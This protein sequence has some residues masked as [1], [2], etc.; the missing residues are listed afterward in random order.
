MIKD[1]LNQPEEV[2]GIGLIYPVSILEWETFSPLAHRFL[3]VG[4]DHLK[5]RLKV[6]EEVKL[7]DFIIAVCLNSED[8][9]ER[10]KNL[11]SL[12]QLIELVV[13]KETRFMFDKG[14]KEWFFFLHETEDHPQINRHNFDQ[15]REVVMRQ[16]LLF[17]P[18]V[19]PN[20]FAQKI[21]DEAIERMNRKGSPVDLESMLAV[22]S[23][24]RGLTPEQLST[25]S[26]YQLRADYEVFQRIE[27]SRIIHL[28]RCQGGKG[29]DIELVAPLSIHEN[30]YGFNRLFDKVDTNRENDLQKMLSR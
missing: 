5:Y 10:V 17:E 12:K 26:Y 21:L 30:P 20:E 29:D 14:T 1:Y 15:F 11:E 23:V 19:A 2:E 24:M 8:E 4:Y 16:N 6:K 9:E 25:Y 18:V 3:L 22:V 27:S 13:R 7:L 28:Y